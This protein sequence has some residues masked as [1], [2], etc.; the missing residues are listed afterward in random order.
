MTQAHW[1]PFTAQR[2][3]YSLGAVVALYSDR[4]VAFP[5]PRA[6]HKLPILCVRI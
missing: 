5:E 3:D 6:V 1:R 4:S 2:V